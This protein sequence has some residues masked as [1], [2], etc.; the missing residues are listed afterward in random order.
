MSRDE[1]V[2]KELGD[3]GTQRNEVRVVGCGA[4]VKRERWLRFVEA[5]DV[6]D[7]EGGGDEGRKEGEEER[8]RCGGDEE[9]RKTKRVCVTV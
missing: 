7:K 5:E 9:Q 4:A 1:V 8:R 6:V 3:G 2:G